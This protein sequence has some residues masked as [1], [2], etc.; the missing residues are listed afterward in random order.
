MP[1]SYTVYPQRE[2]C[3][4]SWNLFQN[5]P[6]FIN[7]MAPSFEKVLRNSLSVWAVLTGPSY[8]DIV[9]FLIVTLDGH[10]YTSRTSE[11]PLQSYHYIVI[12]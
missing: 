9:T 7:G 8:G 2:L 12:H 5:L 3:I 10:E 4:P 11:F 6:S 1:G